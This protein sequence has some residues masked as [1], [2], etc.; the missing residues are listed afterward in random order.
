[1]ELNSETIDLLDGAFDR[2]YRSRGLDNEY[3]R[4][5]DMAIEYREGA[6]EAVNA[7]TGTSMATLRERFSGRMIA[8][9]ER[10]TDNA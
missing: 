5:R 10:S 9:F 6:M 2:C 4:L 8:R 3:R 1:M 7:M